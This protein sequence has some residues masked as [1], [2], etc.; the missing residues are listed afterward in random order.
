[1]AIEARVRR[2]STVLP[3]PDE[4]TP[5][6]I[7]DTLVRHHAAAVDR[8]GRGPAGNSRLTATVGVVL[9]ALVAI[10]GITLV[11]L[12]PLLPAHV[13]VGVLL[14][15]PVLLKLAT[16]G[17]RMVRYYAGSRQYR[18]AG[19]PATLMRMLGPAV[20]VSTVGLFGSGVA[21]L[22]LGP[23]GGW[24]VT[25]HKASF[26]VWIA[27]T[28]V[29]VLGHVLHIP[30]LAS[31]D[32]RGPRPRRRGSLLRRAAV[33]SALVSGLVLAVAALQYTAPWQAVIG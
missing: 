27:V 3:R 17:Y 31:A 18:L 7:R 8:G 12:G 9:L 10:E 2:L 1:M 25:L 24:V 4:L 30:G 11:S 26:V 33:A 16:T 14:I 23:S 32:F 29:H 15:P 28:A 22:A 19:P 6:A 20:V 13:F 21:M 5:E